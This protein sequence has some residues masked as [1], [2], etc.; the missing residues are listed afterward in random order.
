MDFFSERAYPFHENSGVDMKKRLGLIVSFCLAFNCLQGEEASNSRN[1]DLKVILQKVFFHSKAEAFLSMIAMDAAS[2]C[3]K[4]LDLGEVVKKFRESFEED[5]VQAKFRDA[6][7]VF[8][9]AEIQEIRRIYENPVFEKYGQHGT[10]AFQENIA[11]LREIFKE[12]IDV[13]GVEKKKEELADEAELLEI[14]SSNFKKEIE[15]STKPLI[16]D[17]YSN[18]CPP[19]RLMEPIFKELS[20]EYKN[21]IRFVKMNCDDQIEL[22]RQYG[23]TQLP[24]LLFIKPGGEPASMKAIGF[25][26]KKEFQEKIAEFLQTQDLEAAR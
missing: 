23:V 7:A 2:S 18:N 13:H 26:S 5:A 11:S 20:H 6:Y 3:E 21:S 10:Q 16:V 4:T 19:C 8:S 17:V 14:T 25:T 22:A 24:T 12:I 9:D 1:Q 15:E